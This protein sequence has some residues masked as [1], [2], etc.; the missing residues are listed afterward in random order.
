MIYNTNFLKALTIILISSTSMVFAQAEQDSKTIIEEK[1]S[2][3]KSNNTKTTEIK[4][5]ETVTGEIIPGK[6]T[7]V[8]QT[9]ATA[10]VIDESKIT[11]IKEKQYD[12]PYEPYNRVVYEINKNLDIYAL[13]PLSQLYAFIMPLPLKSM[14][15]N[16]FNNIY[17][18]NVFI[19]DTLQGEV[20][21]A[22]ASLSR[23]ALNSTFGIFGLIDVSN[24]AGFP[25]RNND[26]GVTF[27]KWGFTESSYFVIP[28]MGPSTIR[29][30]AG[31]AVAFV[32]TPMSFVPSDY[33]WPL[34]G[35][36]FID[37]RANLL[38]AEKI[39]DTVADDEYVF[40]RN[41]YLEY[42]A[43]L[44]RGEKIDTVREENEQKLLDDILNDVSFDET[45]ASSSSDAPAEV[46]IDGQEGAATSKEN[47][48]EAQDN[49]VNTN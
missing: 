18:I 48:A 39:M 42:R 15:T 45:K 46:Q 4:A 12:D 36:Y 33:S 24:D 30:T 14:V 19:N 13:K 32:T 25:E 23:F 17:D 41:S 40:V 10:A 21:N 34:F 26:Y 16:F 7:T 9:G 22:G 28:L 47:S 11:D 2:E 31:R 20:D 5:G 29:D 3:I 43:S 6:N 38:T 44:I 49:N 35:I 1:S 8:I 37:N 27:G